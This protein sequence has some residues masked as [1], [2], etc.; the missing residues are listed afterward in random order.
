MRNF[1]GPGYNGPNVELSITCLLSTYI[2]CSP[3]LR[4]YF[5]MFEK[6]CGLDAEKSPL[7]A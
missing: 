6:D 5:H 3:P 2:V 1:E 4:L 7:S